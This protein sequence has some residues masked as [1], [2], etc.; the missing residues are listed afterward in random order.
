[1]VVGTAAAVLGAVGALGA[2]MAHRAANHT[3][4]SLAAIERHRWH[5]DG[6]R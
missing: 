3:G 6:P 1:V 5:A 2:W 4:R